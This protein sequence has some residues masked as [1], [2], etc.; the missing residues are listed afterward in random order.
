MSNP[1][2]Q[3]EWPVF[4]IELRPGRE[5]RDMRLHD[6]RYECTLCGAV[7]EIPTDQEPKVVIKATSGSRNMRTIIS[8]GKEIHSCPIGKAA[9]T[10]RRAR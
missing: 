7:L 3:I 5:T 10:S 4:P 1:E 6:G 9:R 2:L 8:E